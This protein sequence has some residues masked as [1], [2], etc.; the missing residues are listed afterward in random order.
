MNKQFILPVLA[1]LALHANASSYLLDFSGNICGTSGSL[2]C[3]NNSTIG[4]TYGSLPGVLS[5]SQRITDPT[6][7]ATY[8]T[9]LVY[10]ENGYGGLQKVATS[11]DLFGV[12]EITFIPSS[13]DKVTLNSFAFGGNV[14]GNAASKASILDYGTKEILWSTS[15]FNPASSPIT[16]SPVVSSESGLIL[17]WGPDAYRVGI[18]NISVTVSPVPEGSSIMFA[19]CG[20][21]FITLRRKAWRSRA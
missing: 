8:H 13:S 20:L 3:S 15:S 9:N 5:V 11:P 10:F 21:V 1:S 12:A 19:V 18:D 2:A 4:R 16:F 14:Y 17:R 7:T 6:G